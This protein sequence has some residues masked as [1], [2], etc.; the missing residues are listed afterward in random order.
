MS[1]ELNAEQ[2]RALAGGQEYPPRIFN[3]QT[4]ESF[5]LIHAELYE[6]IRPILEEEDEIRAIRETY[7]AV[8][9]VLDAEDIS[10]SAK[11]SA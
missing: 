9:K 1:I 6:R 8:D 10:D 3:P 2:Q 4:N 7:A 5:V 11:E